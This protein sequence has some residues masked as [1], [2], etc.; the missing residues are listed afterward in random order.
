MREGPQGQ[1]L[2]MKE[3]VGLPLSAP[4]S[5]HC[6]ETLQLPNGLGDKMMTSWWI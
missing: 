3:A 4:M 5:C 2:G 1:W 6:R